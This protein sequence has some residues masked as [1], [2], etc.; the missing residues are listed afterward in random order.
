MKLMCDEIYKDFYN[1]GIAVEHP[2]PL[3]RNEKREVVE[4]EDLA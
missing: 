4:L 3:W 1:G 2:K